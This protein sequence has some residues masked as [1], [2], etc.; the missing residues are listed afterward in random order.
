[1]GHALFITERIGPGLMDSIDE[2]TAKLNMEQ[3]PLIGEAWMYQVFAVV[4]C[5]LVAAYVVKLILDRLERR[6]ELTTNMWDD[7]LVL[8]RIHI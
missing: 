5:A 7:A 2:L 6:A 3:L 1:M 8:S 4:L